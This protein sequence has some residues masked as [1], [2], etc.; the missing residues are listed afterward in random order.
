M[1]TSLVDTHALTRVCISQTV[2]SWSQPPHVR[3]GSVNASGI[4]MA[5]LSGRL[6]EIRCRCMY[7]PRPAKRLSC[8]ASLSHGPSA[9]ISTFLNVYRA[10]HAAAMDFVLQSPSFQC[11]VPGLVLS[12]IKLERWVRCPSGKRRW[13]PE[14]GLWDSSIGQICVLACLWREQTC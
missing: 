12:Q 13:G 5:R 7:C 4:S 8:P 1:L 14:I 11:F 9:P 2:C 3:L 6:P 10:R